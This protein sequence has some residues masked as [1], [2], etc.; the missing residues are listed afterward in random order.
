MHND[1]VGLLAVVAVAKVDHEQHEDNHHGGTGPADPP[2]LLMVHRPFGHLQIE[3]L[4]GRVVVTRAKARG[5]WRLEAFY[6]MACRPGRWSAGPCKHPRRSASGPVG[7]V[8]ARG[9]HLDGDPE[10]GGGDLAHR[11]GL[12]GATDQT[13]P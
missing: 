1:T 13:H 2:G 11:F 10:H 9:G 8:L 6:T 12:C 7:D 3:I 5:H 4:V